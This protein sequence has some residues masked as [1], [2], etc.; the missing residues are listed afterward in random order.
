MPKPVPC[1]HYDPVTG[2][3]HPHP[4]I[5]KSLNGETYCV[6]SHYYQG[7]PTD[8]RLIPP[9]CALMEYQTHRD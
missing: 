5:V 9:A 3:T 6:V 4:G 1:R 2:C 8:P 7:P